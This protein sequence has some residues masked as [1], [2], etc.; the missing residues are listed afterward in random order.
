[1]AISPAW[2]DLLSLSMAGCNFLA[3]PLSHLMMSGVAAND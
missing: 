2:C 1:L 3:V